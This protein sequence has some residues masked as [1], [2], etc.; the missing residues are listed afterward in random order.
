MSLFDWYVLGALFTLGMIILLML[1][2]PFGE[3]RTRSR[4]AGGGREFIAAVLIMTIA[5]PVTCAV[6]VVGVVVDHE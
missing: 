6:Y 1:F 5:W 4:I 2:D 3:E